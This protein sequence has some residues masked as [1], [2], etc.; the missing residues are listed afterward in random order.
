M[1]G[2]ILGDDEF[3]YPNFRSIVPYL[4]YL[5]VYLKK[6]ASDKFAKMHPDA[7]NVFKK[8]S[9]TTKDMGKM[10]YYVDVEKMTHQDAE[11]KWLRPIGALR[12]EH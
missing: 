8:I 11:K 10:A 6:A 4:Q 12:G 9:F 1:V 2:A 5:V 7:F 3:N